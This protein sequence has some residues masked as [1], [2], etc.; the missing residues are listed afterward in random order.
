MIAYLGKTCDHDV[1][2]QMAL[3]DYTGQQRE[4]EIR[5]RPTG[6][7]YAVDGPCF[8]FSDSRGFVLCAVSDG[9]VGADLELRRD[10]GKYMAVAERF[11]APDEKAAVTSRNFFELYTAKEAYVK[12]TEMGIFSG[13]EKFAALSGRVGNVNIIKFSD[14]DCICAAASETERNVKVKWIYL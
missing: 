12:F 9:E 6:K 7:P 2:V 4:F 13:M 10:A 11:F 8:S 5:L 3:R 1:F 14:G